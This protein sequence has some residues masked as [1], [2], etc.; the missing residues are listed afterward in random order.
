[1]ARRR[2]NLI[3]I[4]VD[5]LRSDHMSLYGY[6]RLTT[7][8]IDRFAESGTVFLDSFSAHIPTTSGYAN[9]LT[10]RDCFGTGIVALRHKGS[11]A[12]GVPTLAEILR[13]RGYESTCVGFRNAAGR[14]F[15]NY[16]LGSLWL[17]FDL[18]TI[19]ITGCSAYIAP[20]IGWS[21]GHTTS[22]AL[23]PLAIPSSPSLQRRTF[24]CQVASLDPAA[25]NGL[26]A[27]SNAGEGVIY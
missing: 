16:R 8:H 1:M 21:F 26:A 3:L 18:G 27:F 13:D 19:G 14:G 23:V 4:G 10:G 12:D 6:P 15:D 17:P 25:P 7:S 22:T 20:M 2:P 11:I 5:S 9:M 24:Y